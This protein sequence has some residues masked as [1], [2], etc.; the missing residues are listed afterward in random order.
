M[1][2]SASIVGMLICAANAIADSPQLQGTYG[3]TRSFRCIV[4]S[5][6]FDPNDFHAFDG[7]S[8]DTL[9]EYGT[10]TFNGDGT[11]TIDST[12]IAIIQPNLTPG[13]S[14]SH[15]TTPFRYV[16]NRDGS[17]GVLGGGT[18]SGTIP[19]GPRAG[20]TFTVTNS[21]PSTGWISV[22]AQTL[23]LTTLRPNIETITY[24]SGGVQVA[25]FER[26]CHQSTT[27]ISLQ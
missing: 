9:A 5:S 25:S 17:W 19:V 6:G 23:T 26:I 7:A 22:N 18:Y 11:G 12:N 1:L 3:F 27:L 13:A 8:G 2:L 10:F 4:S 24:Y 16:V 20:Q 15:V 21:T 14:L